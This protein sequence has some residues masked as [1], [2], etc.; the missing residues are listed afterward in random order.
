M[1]ASISVVRLSAITG[2]VVMLAGCGGGSGA[3]TALPAGSTSSATARLASPDNCRHTGDMSASVC[4]VKLTTGQPDATISVT[5]PSSSTISAKAASC[6][7]RGLATIEGSGSTWQLS[8]GTSGGRC[9]V[10]FVA[11]SGGEQIGTVDVRVFNKV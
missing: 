6:T 9:I 8:A 2:A 3:S 11:T 7:G 1:F 5:G 4:Y 10:R